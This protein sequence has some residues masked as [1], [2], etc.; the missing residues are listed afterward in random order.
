MAATF[1]GAGEPCRGAAE[2]QG[3][4]LEEG[5]G[6]GDCICRAEKATVC[7]ALS[8]CTQRDNRCLEKR[9]SCEAKR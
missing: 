8:R 7:P 2:G 1:Y 9:M 5:H 4:S 3:R 6:A